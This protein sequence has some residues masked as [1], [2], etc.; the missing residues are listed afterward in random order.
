LIARN[1]SQA[2]FWLVPL[3]SIAGRSLVRGF[4][5]K[6]LI[7][8]N[9]YIPLEP[10]SSQDVHVNLPQAVE[11]AGLSQKLGF[12][13]FVHGSQREDI[14][15]DK[16]RER[17]LLR[18]KLFVKY[19]LLPSNPAMPPSLK[20]IVGEPGRGTNDWVDYQLLAAV[21]CSAV[22]FLVSNDDRLLRKARRLGIA[23]RVLSL[24][25]AV[26]ALRMLADK[27]GALPPA[28]KS[29]PAYDL[30]IGDTIW[31]SF[32][33]DYPGFNG[34]LEM[35]QHEHRQ[36]W[37]IE[38]AD[39]SYAAIAIVKTEWAGKAGETPRKLKICS[40]KV[41][42]S[43][44]G[45]KLGELLLKS[46]FQYVLVNNHD[47]AY[48]T[49]YPKQIG[50]IELLIDFGFAHSGEKPDGELILL[51]PFRWT[52]DER[53]RVDALGFHIR[54]GP[55]AV[56]ADRADVFVVPITPRYHRMLFPDTQ[57][58][59]SL[60]P[61]EQAFGNS[62]KKAYLCHSGVRKVAPGSIL[63]FY[64][65]EDLQT[66]LNVGVVEQTLVS[67]DPSAIRTLVMPRTVYTAREIE[68]LCSKDTLV[69]MFRQCLRSC[70]P[71]S[72]KDLKQHGI[73]RG[74]P[75][76]ITELKGDAKAWIIRQMGM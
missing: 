76:T 39:S 28:V 49:V 63:L 26:A 43:H 7:D 13:L 12:H 23:S 20:A 19:A 5:L 71:I 59:L 53:T 32:R 16:N 57:N 34:W 15:A 56:D 47:E 61:G 14:Q 3:L 27:P 24:E 2:T 73:L 64:R 9:I 67:A 70:E 29:L 37:V 21:A 72:L 25:D 1:N 69:I 6:L 10:C 38:A 36:C 52:E 11:L 42:S 58:Q 55:S 65:S 66:I 18:L 35:C 48:I 74:A 33:V 68:E 46:I 40:F 51:K 54:Y 31:D 44:T 45:R 60:F 17:R 41:S 8:T 62:I 30:K 22:D 50:L 4:R 75:Q